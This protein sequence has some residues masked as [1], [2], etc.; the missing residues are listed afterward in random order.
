[1]YNG[2]NKLI[3]PFVEL[4][5]YMKDFKDAHDVGVS[6]SWYGNMLRTIGSVYTPGSLHWQ[7]QRSQFI[8]AHMDS[9]EI[10]RRLM[11]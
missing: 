5:N 9:Q 6:P 11:A 10:E 8:K 3:Q 4:K 1:M 2:L 7:I